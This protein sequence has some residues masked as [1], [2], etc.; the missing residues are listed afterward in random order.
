MAFSTVTPRLFEANIDKPDYSNIAPAFNIGERLANL[1]TANDPS[2]QF[3]E[4]LKTRM[5]EDQKNRA[6]QNMFRANG[7]D[8][9]G[10]SSLLGGVQDP[11]DV[12]K[13]ISALRSNDYTNQ[14]NDAKLQTELAKAKNFGKD[15]GDPL[16]EQYGALNDDGS[17]DFAKMPPG[18]SAYTDRYGNVRVRVTPNPFPTEWQANAISGENKFGPLVSDIQNL[19]D[20]GALS[21]GFKDQYLAEHGDNWLARM[22]TKDNSPLEQ[23]ASK[24]A[25]VVKY[26]FSEGGKTL[27]P[28]EK[29]IVEAGLTFTGKGNEQ[30]KNDF[31]EAISILGRKGLLATGG[32]MAASQFGNQSGGLTTN[33]GNGASARVSVIDP[34]GRRGT[35][36]ASSLQSALAKGYRQA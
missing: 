9:K 29:A 20:G 22:M 36:S 23:L 11:T 14:L 27:S 34:Q 33:G 18:T 8:F 6:I 28:T 1:R 3:V 7:V 10:G 24:R 13:T 17:I 16:A 2:R 25:E 4:A 35:I 21:G 26:M 15:G 32:K 5:V 12:L 19:I 31:Q 30:I